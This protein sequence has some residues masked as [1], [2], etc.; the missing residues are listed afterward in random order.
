MHAF[1]LIVT[2]ALTILSVNQSPLMSAPLNASQASP[3]SGTSSA[4]TLDLFRD[5]NLAAWCIVPF[6][7][8]KR[9]PEQR[10]AMLE[11]LKLQMFVYDYR[12]EHIPE[13]DEE[14]AA[15]KRHHIQLLGWWF[16]GS[17]NAEATMALELFRKYDLKP[18]LWITGG[19]GSL[20]AESPEEQS[21]R[22]TNEVRR[23]KPIAEA[24]KADAL[25]VGL[26]NHGS[27]F[28]EP[29][30]QIEIIKALQKEGISNVGIV[31]NQHHGH[32]HI[33]GFKSLLERMLPHLI[34]LNIN[35][36]DINGEARGRKILPLGTGTEDL[37]LLKIIRDS[38]YKGPIGILN[39]TGEDAEGRLLDNID[40]LHWLSNQLQEKP[41]L[42]KPLPR[43]FNSAPPA[44]AQKTSS[45]PPP[46]TGV[47]SINP[48]FGKALQGRLLLEGKDAYRTFPLSV[49]CRVK[50]NGSGGFNILVASDPKASADHWELY[51]YMKSGVL[52]VFLP[53]YG[54][55]IK[56]DANICDGNWHAVAAIFDT[57]KARLFVD[58]KMVKEAPLK[59]RSGT[60][61]PGGLAIGSLVDGGVGCDGLIDNVRLS[62][63]TRE[64][65]APAASPLKADA[66]T[67]GLWDFDDLPEAISSGASG[68]QATPV[69]TSSAK[70]VTGI[71][72]PPLDRTQLP[73]SFILPAAAPERLT[74]A[75]GWPAVQNHADWERSL[76]GPTSNRFSSL[77][78][79]TRENVKQLE[80][81][82]T[83][84]SGDGAGNIQCNPIVV[85]GVVY[86]PT[87]GKQIAAIDAATG[88]ERWRFAPSNLIGKG[89][90]S[91]ARRGLLFWK[92]DGQCAPRLLFG[93]GNWLIALN[94]ETGKPIADF[95]DGG[96][97]PVPA[98]TAA[99]GSMFG[100]ICV[101]P[102]YSGD[103]YGYDARDGK[104]LWTFKTRPP[105]G[106][107]GHET[108]SN[109]E[110]GANCW[111]GMAMDESRGI[112][113]IS[114]GSPKPNFIGINHQ[115]D[116]LFSNCVLALDA[117][118]GAR[119][120]HFQE[121]RHDIWDWDI[122]TSPNL[123]TVERHGRRVDALAQVTKL[124][125]TLL[126]DRVT[127][128]PLYDFRFLRVDTHG[129]PGD[130]TSAYQPAP[131][132]PPP[133]ARQAY[134]RA[135]MPADTDAR[136]ALL[137]LLE[138]ANL[139]PFPS[140]DE[141][142][143]TLLFNIHGGA[144]WTGAAADPKGFLYVTSN[145]I[146]WSITCFRDD[147]PAPLVPASAG[148][149]VY[150]THCAPCHGPDRKGIG[151]APPLRGVRHRLTDADVR[152]MLKTGRAAMPP[153]AHLSE[154][155]IQP[156]LDFILCR[157]RPA[158]TETN[159]RGSDWTFAGF[160]RLLD[161]NGY[162]ACSAP[163]G[164][165]NCINLN[166]GTIAWQV[167]LGE[168]PE[169]TA[170]GVPKTGQENFGGAMVT[171]TGLVFASGTRDKKIRAF[172]S[173]TGKELW[174]YDLPLHGTAPPT[175][176]EAE[177]RQFIL[178][179]ATGSGKLGGRAGDS[180]VAFALPK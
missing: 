1:L 54:G 25:M 71:P 130:N 123:V 121:L 14:M 88:K 3:A 137:P 119:L 77:T 35:G 115:G 148:E 68:P 163:W 31:Y 160:N 168:Y 20:K 90:T 152:A 138:R 65:G 122:P 151:H 166:T 26:Y 23:I 105:S 125:N 118:T 98:G 120:W 150:Q 2:L 91:P 162:P 32:G 61:L 104:C 117:A 155:Q 21:R 56:S 143:P 177:G 38:G 62:S 180:W 10:A 129:L 82:W 126:L 114:L 39:H 51:T 33:E 67:L 142:R 58:G 147:D 140:F 158:K 75:N 165:L 5:S 43:T 60:P 144:E 171:A 127:G 59:P 167:P 76:G 164:T 94:P 72:T 96:K 135:D 146:P 66:Q 157:D 134:Q 89:S 92:G 112:A 74:R 124:G 64:I 19:G 52:S 8:A 131:E 172:D 83:Y 7:K 15:L 53:G 102:G 116:N 42:P 161:A 111:G 170:K 27:W 149:L 6:D 95:G 49:E 133:F 169:L 40:G 45:L 176:Y 80:P 37:A 145:E 4:D 136:T 93:D 57:E 30:N 48:A 79:I 28:G 44:Q 36:M 73:A 179:P 29:D 63:G 78:Q 24:A 85:K 18:Q 13:W 132:T 159:P 69:T 173:E 46:A 100:H 101:V 109:L 139:G 175:C 17:L 154:V 128:E 16:P 113:F 174:S 11:R 9:S 47:S 97:T 70:P 99:A 153:M 12:K 178:Q 87:P 141:A 84:H 86:T 103:V 81:A 22:V 55:E 50:L 108:W 34:C 156:L 107:Y 110:S 106:E 41:A